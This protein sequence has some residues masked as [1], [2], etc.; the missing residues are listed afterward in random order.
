MSP[1]HEVNLQLFTRYL[2]ILKRIEPNTS[3][4]D[5]TSIQYLLSMCETAIRHP[6]MYIDK[7]SRWLGYIQGVLTMRG[8]INVQEERDFSRPLYQ[9]AY[10]RMGLEQPK[11]LE[12]FSE[13]YP[14]M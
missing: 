7:H 8:H 6:E 9:D 1:L 11:T 3:P 2:R 14:A 10:R 12:V 5:P 13:I 4:D